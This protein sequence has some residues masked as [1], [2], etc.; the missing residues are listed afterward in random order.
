MP[1]QD[2]QG[3]A[4][5]VTGSGRNIGRAIAH[6]L[7]KKGARVVVNGSSNKA[8]VETVVA[9]INAAGGTAIGVMADVSKDAE[10]ELLVRSCVD[11][12]GGIDIMVNNVGIRRYQ[13]F[14]DITPED[15]D[16]VLR[17]NLSSAFFLSRH[18]IPHMRK[19]KWGRIVLIS[20]FDGFW[21][22]V[23]HRAHNITCKAGMHGLAKAIAREFGPD[24][25]T[26]NTV[27]PGAIDTERDWSQYP[28]QAKEKIQSEIPLGRFGAVEEVAAAVAFLA[29]PGGGFVSG[30]ATHVNGGHYM[31]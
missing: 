28:H 23:T 21:A 31:I 10:C 20:G 2:L 5:I 16:N 15:W 8:A 12:F 19:N 18:A 27:V 11:A 25:I 9:E 1:E 22:Q 7:A 29:S 24:G 30:Q 3:R 17:T 13:S 6:A 14:L 26:A 4:A